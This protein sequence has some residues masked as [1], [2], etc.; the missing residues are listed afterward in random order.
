MSDMQSPIP[1]TSGWLGWLGYDLTREIEPLLPYKNDPL[2]FIVAFW[3]YPAISGSFLHR[4]CSEKS[5][6]SSLELKT[7]D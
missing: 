1:F 6:L 3:L 7:Q 5:N 4:K 2:P